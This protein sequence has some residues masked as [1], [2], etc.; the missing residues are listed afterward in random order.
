MAKPSVWPSR[1]RKR[2]CKTQGLLDQGH[3]ILTDAHGSLVVLT[4]AYTLRTSHPLWNSS[5]QNKGG[6]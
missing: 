4:R 2:A 1:R 5:A 6:A 3:Q